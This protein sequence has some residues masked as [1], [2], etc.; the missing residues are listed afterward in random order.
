M[1]ANTL[2]YHVFP[3]LYF[4][5]AAITCIR[6]S[7]RQLYYI[8]HDINQFSDGTHRYLSVFSRE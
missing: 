5:E 4:L 3:P 1:L 7:N 8:S 6:G 2:Q